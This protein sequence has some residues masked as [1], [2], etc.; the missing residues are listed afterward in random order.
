MTRGYQIRDGGYAGGASVG[1]EDLAFC[2]AFR[3]VFHFLDYIFKYFMQ[4]LRCCIF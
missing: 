3:F 2:K 1:C 4:H